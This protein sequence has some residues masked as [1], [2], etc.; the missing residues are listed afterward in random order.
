[1]E[2]CV[3]RRKANRGLMMP[4]GARSWTKTSELGR[5]N[6][7]DSG[8]AAKPVWI[9]SVRAA[10][11][12]QRLLESLNADALRGSGPASG[13]SDCR[14]GIDGRSDRIAHRSVARR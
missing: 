6:D 9:G 5:D 3:N 11:S 2:G 14:N 8:R 7:G 12:W 1:M 4:V 10:W 13:M